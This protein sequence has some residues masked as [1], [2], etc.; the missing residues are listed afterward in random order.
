MAGAFDDLVPQAVAPPSPPGRVFKAPDGKLVML[1]ADATPDQVQAA[2][3]GAHAQTGGGGSYTEEPAASGAFDDLLPSRQVQPSGYE[4]A[5]AD[6]AA[7]SDMGVEGMSEAILN[8]LTFNHADDVKGALAAAAYAAKYLG[9]DHRVSPADA[10]LAERDLSRDQGASFAAVH[11]FMNLGLNALGGAPLAEVAGGAVGA[12]PTMAAKVGTGVATGAALG[13]AYG[14]GADKQDA[15]RG[16]AL[17]LGEGA[18]FGLAAPVLATAG[19]GLANAGR[20]VIDQVGDLVGGPGNARAAAAATNTAA[21]YLA[22]KMGA[23][24]P[25]EI[26]TSPVAAR[27]GT[28]AE[29]MGPDAVADAAALIRRP[30]AA[31][32]LAR[33]N[34]GPRF[35][36]MTKNE[37]LVGAV[38][39]ATGVDP[40]SAQGDVDA[41]IA[42]G[43]QAASPAYGALRSDSNRY[44]TP[45]MRA[46]LNTDAGQAALRQTAVDIGNNIPGGGPS[47]AEMGITFENGQ[48]VV[49]KGLRPAAIDMVK[50]NLDAATKFNPMGGAAGGNANQA[51]DSARD[52]F[53]SSARAVVP[54]YDQALS[55]AADYKAVQGAYRAAQGTLFGNGAGKSV[56]DVQA[57]MDGAGT[58]AERD[59][60]RAR[61]AAD[62]MQKADA[63]TLTAGSLQQPGVAK[64]LGILFGDGAAQSITD[65]AAQHGQLMASGARLLPNSGSISSDA[66]MHAADTDGALDGL[67]TGIHVA[68]RFAE[69]KPVSAMMAA[70][71]HF[72]GSAKNV[73]AAPQAQATRDAI[74]ALYLQ[75]A[76]DFGGFA[77]PAAT[78]TS[79]AL[80]YLT[81]PH[82]LGARLLPSYTAAREKDPQPA[83]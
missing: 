76:A 23:M 78:A 6:E 37:P 83:Y 28:V 58:D 4:Q 13:A 51:V 35:D 74:A 50:R 62:L 32:G 30:G 7:S 61:A 55:T 45:T 80:D 44:M 31:A 46:V 9:G 75:P 73:M 71:S 19:R 59:A 33:A 72:A 68:H 14:A 10:F 48:P 29:A 38:E 17:G 11:P 65:A 26:A 47:H 49:A 40:A 21:H 25:Q 56:A 2:M 41:I 77:P 18:A 1:A 70:A 12:A 22:G 43:R 82:F 39:Q 20:A 16:A 27:G 69:G 60:I 42:N 79:Q 3:A 54:N 34:V 15:A 64:K 67:K 24:T 53:V 8:G 81:A 63:G 57:L 5:R 36:P 52:A 66:L